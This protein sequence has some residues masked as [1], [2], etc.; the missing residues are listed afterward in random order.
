MPGMMFN[1]IRKPGDLKPNPFNV[2]IYGTEE[3]DEELLISI[4]EKGMLEPIVIKDDGTIISGHRRWLALKKLGIDANCRTITFDNEL[5][6]KECLIEFNRQ[7]KKT[8]TQMMRESEELEEIVKAKAKLRQLE[9]GRKGNE[10]RKNK[11]KA[12]C[13]ENAKKIRTK[14]RTII[15]E[16]IGMKTETYRKTKEIWNKAKQGDTVAKETF[17]KLDSG[18]ITTHAAHTIVKIGE[19]AHEGNKSAEKLL[20]K[21][22]SG[23]ITPNMAIKE[24]KK[25]ESNGITK[26][27]MK[28]GKC[29]ITH[30]TENKECHIII[31]ESL[32]HKFAGIDETEYQYYEDS[33]EI[34]LIFNN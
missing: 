19:K 6:E 20:K 23:E 29:S 25:I 10:H 4:K 32:Q 1:V 13:D 11:I 3:V 18:G 22:T 5:D 31:P 15:A 8:A 21:V 30:D 7:R 14:S 17:K 24:L 9:G 12:K 33:E 2:D 16:K 34:K 26:F 27:D 28:R